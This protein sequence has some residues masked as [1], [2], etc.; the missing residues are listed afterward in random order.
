MSVSI[1]CNRGRHKW[2]GMGQAQVCKNC[3]ARAMP[4]VKQPETVAAAKP[5]KAAK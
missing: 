3:G 2:L 5:K 1:D 4:E